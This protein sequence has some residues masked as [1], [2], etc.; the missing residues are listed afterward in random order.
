MG[1]DPVSLAAIAGLAGAATSAVGAYTT[2][3]ANSANATYQAQVAANN[4]QIAQQNAKMDIQSGEVAAVNQGLKT[5]AAVG[6]EKANQGAAGIDVNGPS[7]SDVRAGTQSM[8]MLDALT[9]RSDAAKQAYAQEV[10]ATSDTAQGELLTAQA[11]QDVTAG[12][13]SAGGT[14]LS[15][16][17]TVGSN[18]AKFQLNN[19]VSPT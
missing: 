14:L 2:G 16:A 3:Q 5:R 11:G 15:G 6:T 8:G 17:S 7:A 19:G 10:A 4:A 13:L 12:D 9:I 1:F 18:W